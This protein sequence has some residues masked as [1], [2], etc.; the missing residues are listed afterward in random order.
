M[1]VNNA[2]FVSKYNTVTNQLGLH[3]D[4][5][6]CA[7]AWAMELYEK[8]IIT[9]EDTDGIELTWGNEEAILQLLPKIAYR[10]GFGDILDG[11]PLRAV[12]KLGRGSEIYASSVKGM[13]GRGTGIEGSLEWLLGL[14]VSTRGRD[15]LT[16]T[17][18]WCQLIGVN[19][20]KLQEAVAEYGKKRYGDSKLTAELWHFTPKKA[21]LVYDQEN[22]YAL[23][24][25][26]GV[27]KFASEMVAFTTGYH[28]EDFAAILSAATGV[29]FTTED[30][31]KAAEREMLIERAFNAREGI[32]RIDDY[33]VPFHWQKKHNKP[34][35][36]YKDTKF[37]LTIEQY[38]E[39]LDEYYRLRGCE[40]E[41]GI[42]MMEK[43]NLLGLEDV[44]EDM[45][46]L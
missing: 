13:T 12:E 39:L 16:G 31:V 44:E 41:T 32:R 27:C 46:R 1:R 42:P 15:H 43:L 35:P 11:Y 6:G 18:T 28:Q 17:P 30:L 29:D 24:D 10:E 45:A 22:I 34:H 9:K 33:P 26:T 37:P 3:I 4:T 7:I 20:R 25:M 14:A 21:L 38:D 5:P 23:C 8:G 19:S 36:K 2:A 40:M